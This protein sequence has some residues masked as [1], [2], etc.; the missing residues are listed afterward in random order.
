MLETCFH[1]TSGILMETVWFTYAKCHYPGT[2]SVFLLRKNVQDSDKVQPTYIETQASRWLLVAKRG[3]RTLEKRGWSEC[4]V[5]DEN[6]KEVKELVHKVM[7]IECHLWNTNCVKNACGQ[8]KII[9]NTVN[10]MLNIFTEAGN[11]NWANCSI[12]LNTTKMLPSTSSLLKK[13]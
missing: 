11:W 6:I 3:Y 2:G 5:N 12:L 4:S 13:L 10:M 1:H 7:R 8:F 9:Q